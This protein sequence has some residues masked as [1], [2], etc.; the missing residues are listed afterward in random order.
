MLKGLVLEGL[1]PRGLVLESLVLKGLVLKCLVLRGL[2]LK[3]L[4]LEGL[5]PRGLVLKFLVPRGLVLKKGLVLKG[6]SLKTCFLSLKYVRLLGPRR[7][8]GWSSIASAS[9]SMITPRVNLDRA[10]RRVP[11]G[12]KARRFFGH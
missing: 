4:V 6:L 10:H 9:S 3:G 8:A 5:V 7:G 11:T 12:W 1:V 2:V